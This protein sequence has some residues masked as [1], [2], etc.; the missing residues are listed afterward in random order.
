MGAGYMSGVNLF[1][2]RTQGTVS[3]TSAVT[4]A[5]VAL[6]MGG[7]NQV[8]VKNID[9]TN[10]AYVNFG[11]STVAATVPSGSTGG[12]IP[13]GAGETAGFTVPNGTT[14]AAAICTAG[15]P[16]VYFTPGQGV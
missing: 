5:N 10:I 4:T 16:I 1:T 6:T 3:I 11:A 14:H 8:R 2:P 15:T 13:I 7:G 9:A 12:S